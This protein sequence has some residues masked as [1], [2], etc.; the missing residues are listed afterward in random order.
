MAE[1]AKLVAGVTAVYGEEYVAR[2]YGDI[3]PI[4][5]ER[6]IE[7]GEGTRISLG[8]RAT[9]LS[10]YAWACPSSHLYR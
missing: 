3:L 4:P 7:A 9:A 6:I 10:R 8:S 1:P 5:A 2:V